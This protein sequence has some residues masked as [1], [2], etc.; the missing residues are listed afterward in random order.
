MWTHSLNWEKKRKRCKQKEK[1]KGEKKANSKCIFRKI[2]QKNVIKKIKS[3]HYSFSVSNACK[4]HSQCLELNCLHPVEE[5]N[6]A[7]RYPDVKSH[8]EKQD[9]TKT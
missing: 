2:W 9:L 1:K 7:N 5:I 6:V 4:N 3:S 8:P